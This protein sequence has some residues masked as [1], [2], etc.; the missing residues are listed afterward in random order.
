[1]S[2]ALAGPEYGVKPRH[3]GA[4]TTMAQ[5]ITIPNDNDPVMNAERQRIVPWAPT[6]GW[7]YTGYNNEG[8]HIAQIRR[9]GNGA[10]LDVLD[11]D[12]HG[13][14][15]VFNH[16]YLSTGRHENISKFS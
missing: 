1:V 13:N 4:K 11:F 9:V 10:S 7:I 3:Q 2:A 5:I 15:T 6:H 14:P 12:C 16:T 8:D